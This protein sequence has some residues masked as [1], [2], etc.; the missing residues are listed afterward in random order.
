VAASVTACVA[1]WCFSERVSVGQEVKTADV[2]AAAPA[3]TAPAA[4]QPAAN[5]NQPPQQ[6]PAGT[7]ADGNQ[8]AQGK[9]DANKPAEDNKPKPVTRSTTPPSEKNEAAFDVKPDAEGKVQFQF[10]GAPWPDLIEWLGKASGMAIDWQELPGDFV[11]LRTQRRYTLAEARDLINRHLLAR[12]YTLVEE[13]E[14]LTVVKTAEVNTAL[15]P[16]VEP[17]DLE[18]HMPHEFVKVSFELD[19]LMAEEAATELKPMISKNGQLNPLKN[20]NRLEAVDAV[21]NLLQIYRVLQDEQSVD[22]QQRL[23]EEFEL[24]HARA[25]QVKE[26]L[27]QLL[28][29]KKPAAPMTPEQLQQQQQMLQMQAQMRQQRGQQPNPNENKEDVDI[30]IVV[31]EFRNSILVLA[32]PDKMAVV[33]EAVKLLDVPDRRSDSL[34][35][36]VGRIR[37]YRLTTLDPKEIVNVL[38]ETGAMDPETHLKA[39]EKSKAIIVS[40]PP[41]DHLTVEKLIKKLDGSPRHA[42]V[43]H[44]RR[45]RADQVATTLE[46]LMVAPKEDNNRSRRPYWYYDDFYNRNSDDDKDRFRVAADVEHNWLLLWCNETEYE[47]VVDLLVQ[48][49]EITVR[50]GNSKQARLIEEIDPAEVDAVLQRARETFRS[51]APNPVLLPETQPTRH[52]L[53]RGSDETE[54]QTVPETSQPEITETAIETA[55]PDSTRLIAQ[56]ELD[57]PGDVIQ[58]TNPADRVRRTNDP[59]PNSVESSG[60]PAAGA[61]R[62]PQDENVR[63]HEPITVT[64]TPDGRL[65]IRSEDTAALDLFEEFLNEMR[66]PKK[67]YVVFQLKHASAS[68]VSLQLEDFFD[69]GEDD[70]TRRRSPYFWDY[71]DSGGDDSKKPL[72][73]ADQRPIRFISEIDTNTIVVRNGT[74]DQL[75]TVAELI[76]LYDVPEPVNHQT[77]RHTKLIA[78]KYSKASIIAGQIKDAF[79][80]LLSGNDKAF[81]QQQQNQQQD[82]QQQR[83]RND[84]FA[85]YAFGLEF[86]EGESKTESSSTRATFKG[87]LSLGVDDVTNTLLVST[88]GETLMDVIESMIEKLDAAARTSDDVRIVRIDG[89][90]NGLHEA[91]RSTFGDKVTITQQPA[92]PAEK[93]GENRPAQVPPNNNG[94]NNNN[95][96]SAAPA[97]GS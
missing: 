47:A 9:P 66:P 88:E 51:F 31:S 76:K 32:T 74:P 72:G 55:L 96:G 7:P 71:Y 63:E 91:L 1:S 49:G 37:T 93:N 15:V 33:A 56:N 21:R 24:K 80:D 8:P 44:L 13:G 57:P 75:S 73:L 18:K 89:R 50:G 85:A 69:D 22:S 19:W 42:Q 12:G 34:D 52:L 79:R 6:N 23:V 84:L 11:N 46:N 87:K 68:W 20:T 43:I 2:K 67:D 17:E 36:L 65:M 61:V 38:L 30:K 48:L 90:M 27:E 86:G 95:N 3:A 78:I 92:Q 82:Q 77:A 54:N 60:T 70:N 59:D 41:W 25:A 45:R 14:L 4:T 94:T 64:R 62:N 83:Q 81:Q 28:S 53:E 5:P 29:S 16:R 26:K 97:E 35:T 39:D 58:Q 40:G 10:E